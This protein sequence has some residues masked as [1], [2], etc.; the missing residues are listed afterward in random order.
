MKPILR[1]IPSLVTALVA[2]FVGA[3][4]STVSTNSVRYPGSRTFPPSDPA[5]VEV[6]RAEPTRPHIR[7]GEVRPAPFSPGVDAKTIETAL[8]QEAA[9]LGADAVVVVEDRVQATNK[10]VRAASSSRSVD[11][12]DQRIIIAVAI[13]Y[14]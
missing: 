5:N 11:P 9:R 13:K 2:V 8:R 7:L 10:M 6:L 1:C 4:C 14:Q 12:V 3:G